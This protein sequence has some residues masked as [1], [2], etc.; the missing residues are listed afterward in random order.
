MFVIAVAILALAAGS[1]QASQVAAASNDKDKDSITLEY[2]DPF[3]LTVM[4][5]YPDSGSIRLSTTQMSITGG[6]ILDQ[7]TLESI[8]YPPRIW[9]PERPV[10]RSPCIPSW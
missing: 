5:L 6:G 8:A 7:G 9:I 2:L 10:F 4:S 1:R 3:D